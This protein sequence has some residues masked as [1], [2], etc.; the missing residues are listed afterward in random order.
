[1][2]TG[3]GE[4][5]HQLFDIFG[6]DAHALLIAVDPAEGVD[7]LVTIVFFSYLLGPCGRQHVVCRPDVFERE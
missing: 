4:S 6:S 7:G 1:M 5:N 3:V 2:G